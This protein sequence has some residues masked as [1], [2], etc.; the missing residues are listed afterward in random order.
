M[1]KKPA[2]LPL[3]DDG[4]PALGAD[5]DLDPTGADAILAM[6]DDL[7]EDGNHTWAEETLTGIR[8]TIARTGQAT[9]GQQDAINNIAN[10]RAQRQG[11]YPRS[12]RY[13]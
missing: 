7:L 11:R 4:I 3:R 12:R 2:D 8:E 10:A 9:Q 5:R 6:I 1:S 13:S